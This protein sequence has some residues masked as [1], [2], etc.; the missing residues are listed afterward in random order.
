MRFVVFV[1]LV[2]FSISSFS[3]GIDSH[4]RDFPSVDLFEEY[5]DES[6]SDCL[7]RSMGATRAVSCYSEYYNSWQFEMNYY[8]ELL[9]TELEGKNLELLESTQLVSINYRDVTIAFNSVLLDRVY[10]EK[11]GTMYTAMRAGDASK[12]ITPII[13]SRALLIQTWYEDIVSKS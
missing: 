10:A 11:R 6:K 5:L 13:R 1:Y 12:I 9:I 4:L 7:N 3:Q 2:C 8:Y